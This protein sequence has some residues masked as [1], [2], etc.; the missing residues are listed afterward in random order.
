MRDL[1]GVNVRGHSYTPWL[2]K[3]TLPLYVPLFALVFPLSE[4]LSTF[5]IFVYY[6][7]FR[8]L[9]HLWLTQ[10]CFCNGLWLGYNRE[11]VDDLDTFE[12]AR[13]GAKR[14]LEIL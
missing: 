8:Y 2:T 1:G 14:D 9:R 4:H 3:A 12:Y 6:I 13:S 11:H 7:F 10:P 5:L